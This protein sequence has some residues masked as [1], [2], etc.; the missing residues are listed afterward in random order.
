MS[1]NRTRTSTTLSLSLSLVYAD[2]RPTPRTMGT[3][4]EEIFLRLPG[5]RKDAPTSIV[6]GGR[7]PGTASIKLSASRRSARGLWPAQAIDSVT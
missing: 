6:F 3:S 5:A 4:L 1:S 7:S 2:S